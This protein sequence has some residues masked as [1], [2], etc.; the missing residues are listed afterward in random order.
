ML[1]ILELK[2]YNFKLF[3]PKIN[4][5]ITTGLNFSSTRYLLLQILTTSLYFIGFSSN[6]FHINY[7]KYMLHMLKTNDFL[8]SENEGISTGEQRYGHAE[9][10]RS[11]KEWNC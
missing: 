8:F 4:F 2:K 10:N 6:S 9:R 3:I 1:H 5:E 11:E 7:L